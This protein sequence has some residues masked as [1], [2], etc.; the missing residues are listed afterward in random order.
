MKYLRN[1]TPTAFQNDK[2]SNTDCNNKKDEADFC[3]KEDTTNKKH[4]NM[5]KKKKKK[6]TKNNEQPQF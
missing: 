4:R 6:K 1:Y 2:H 3:S 5:K